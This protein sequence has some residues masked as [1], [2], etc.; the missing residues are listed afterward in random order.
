MPRVS[1]IMPTYDAMPFLVD[2][3]NSILQ[4]TFND[5]ELLIVND[6]STDGS[7]EYLD[8]LQDSRVR[9]IHQENLGL[10][11]A[12]NRLLD[13]ARGEYIARLD[14][15]DI[16]EPKRLEAQVQ[17]LSKNPEADAVFCAYTK[18]G[19]HGTW[20][21]ADKFKFGDT[22]SLTEAHRYSPDTDGMMVHSILMAKR[23][24][25]L[26]LRYN[27]EVYPTEDG[28]FDFRLAERYIAYVMPLRLVKYRMLSDSNTVKTFFTMQHHIR[29]NYENSRHR[30]AG[31]PEIS[32]DEYM[33]REK[34]Q[35]LRYWNQV[36]IDRAKLHFRQAGTYYL[37]GERLRFIGHLLLAVL[38]D[39]GILGRFV[40]AASNRF[41][42]RFRRSVLQERTA[43]PRPGEVRS[44]DSP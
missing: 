31:Q 3:V 9:V 42:G 35:P 26:D 32:F 10:V 27:A 6:G 8:S 22:G 18:I 19:K 28:D 25:F 24:V 4:Q 7:R 2:A 40:K 21:N 43:T 23:E 37:D 11:D 41:I 33:E 13:E 39:V 20:D 36:R 17:F 1:V 34:R 15:D 30:R 29:H 14:S 38:C 12:L 44:A 5:F 16:S